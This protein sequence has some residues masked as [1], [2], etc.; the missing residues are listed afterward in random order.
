MLVVGEKVRAE[1]SP[2]ITSYLLV[3]YIKEHSII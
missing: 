1:Y 3:P 2:I